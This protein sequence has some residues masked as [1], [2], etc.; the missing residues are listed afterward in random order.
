MSRSEDEL[1][2]SELEELQGDIIQAIE[3]FDQLY[4]QPKKKDKKGRKSS[5]KKV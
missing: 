2:A 4:N 3:K 5:N 1:S